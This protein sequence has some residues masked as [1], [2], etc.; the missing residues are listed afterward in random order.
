MAGSRNLVLE[1][2]AK[3][4]N[5]P[6][7]A[8]TKVYIGSVELPAHE[9][10]LAI[11]S[12]FF[13]KALIGSF[14]E[15]RTKEFR[16]ADGSAH[17]H[18]RVFEYMYTGDYSEE[19]NKLLDVKGE[20][21]R[22]VFGLGADS[23]I[24]DDELIKHVRVYVTADFFLLDELKAYAL[25]RFK[26][27]LQKLWVNKSLM[28]CIREIYSSTNE[29]EVELRNAVVKVAKEHLNDLWP[30]KAFQ[31]LVREGGNFAVDFVG[32]FYIATVLP[33]S[34]Q[35]SGFVFGHR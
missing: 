9:V 12:P 14:Q 7:H 15:S 11:Q 31:A 22:F 30:N 2:I 34:N 28:D 17:A 3:L 18:W 5:N 35:T 27:K 29:S 1:G 26:S 10:V 16:F 21:F 19:A 20:H 4:F 23:H 33:F 8:D 24:D 13:K 25:K 32:Q 6:E